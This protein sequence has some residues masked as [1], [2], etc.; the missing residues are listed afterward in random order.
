MVELIDAVN[1]SF[2]LINTYIVRYGTITHL[3]QAIVA[4]RMSG[5]WTF[6]KVVGGRSTLMGTTTVSLSI[7]SAKLSIENV[8]L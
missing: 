6:P 2:H 8:S 4:K 3:S 7:K 5:G 1:T